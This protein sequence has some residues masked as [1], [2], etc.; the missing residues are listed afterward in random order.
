MDL[1]KFKIS[2]KTIIKIIKNI[3][4]QIIKVTDNLI[5]YKNAKNQ[6]KGIVKNEYLKDCVLS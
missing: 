5:R 3:S 6:I 1:F 4:N 2:V